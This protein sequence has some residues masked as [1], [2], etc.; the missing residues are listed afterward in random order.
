MKTSNSFIDKILPKFGNPREN[1]PVY[2][3][4]QKMF[5]SSHYT[6]AAGNMYF[7]G[8]RFTDRMVMIEKVGLYKNFSYIDSVEVF[9]FD[10]ENKILIGKIDYDK[11]FYNT[12]RI[13][14]DTKTIITNYLEDSARITGAVIDKSQAKAQ[15][16]QLLEAMYENPI[17]SAIALKNAYKQLLLNE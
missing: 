5:M 16:V 4:S 12:E 8:L 7:K 2:S 11:V 15:A 1:I 10:G 9:A 3:D 6:S 14:E 17:R 13:K